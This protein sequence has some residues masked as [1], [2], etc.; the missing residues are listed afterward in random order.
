MRRGLRRLWGGKRGDG[1]VAKMVLMLLRVNTG[2][3]ARSYR[4]TTTLSEQDSTVA[5]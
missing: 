1:L 2:R 5:S 3:D 4:G